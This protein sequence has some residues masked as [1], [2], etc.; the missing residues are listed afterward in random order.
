MWQCGGRIEILPCSRIAHIERHHKP[1]AL[2]LSL[3]LKC[4][5]LRVA[6][7]WMDE[8]KHMVY[9]AWNIPL[10]VC[11]GFEQKQGRMK[12]E[13]GLVMVGNGT[14]RVKVLSQP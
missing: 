14:D 3:P 11:R 6:E 10:Q 12:E 4:S 5:A 2:D 7:I 13:G 9:L 1:Y 8:Y